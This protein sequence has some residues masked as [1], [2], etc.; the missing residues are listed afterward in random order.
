MAAQKSIASPAAGALPKRKRGHARVEA[1]LE[2]ATALF[3]TRG[4]AA[5]TMTEVAS[6]SA[7]AIGSLYR[8][9]PTKEALAAAVLERYGGLLTG[10][11][12]EVAAGAR[13]ASAEALADL[14]VDMM[15]DLKS[16]RAAALALVDLSEDGA[17]RRKAISQAML[18]R[19]GAILAA[20]SGRRVS[21]ETET[22]ALLLLHVLKTIRAL[23]TE[24]GGPLDR[25][26]RRLVALYLEDARRRET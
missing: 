24:R 26:S 16:A 3:A 10:A 12:D 14:L 8:F 2:A 7:T 23:D 25:E 6:R 11:L 9:F 17:E 22:Q 4:F 1:I 20:F 15:L 19:L 18:E 21:Q 13:G 5:V